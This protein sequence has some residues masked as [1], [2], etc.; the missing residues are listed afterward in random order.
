M[1]YLADH[2]DDPDHP[3]PIQLREIAENQNLSMRYLE[4]LV[5]PLKS[6]R[7]IKSVHGKHGG[8]LLGRKPEETSVSDIIEASIG[9][10]RLLDCL[11]PDADCEFTDECGSRR[12][13]GLINVRITDVLNEYT[14]ADLSEKLLREK[15]ERLEKK[16]KKAGARTC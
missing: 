6:A 3:T 5:I 2:A 15:A 4:Q 12:M 16:G 7:L 11:S 9:P 8:Y 13:W 10:I 14:L 1:I